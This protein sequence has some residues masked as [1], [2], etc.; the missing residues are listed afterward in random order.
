M[1]KYK[2]GDRVYAENYASPVKILKVVT[3]D[4]D[5]SIYKVEVGFNKSIGSCFE[6]NL[7]GDVTVVE[8][9]SP[10]QNAFDKQTGG[11]HYKNLVIQPMEY[12]LK[13][14]LNYAQSN[15]IKYITR[16]TAKNGLEDLKKAIHCIELLIEYEYGN[17]SDDKRED[18][19]GNFYL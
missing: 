13:N 5:K 16:Y 18:W 14:K 9:N 10:K 8:Q 17:A 7:S 15:A 4:G 11:N 12:A 2:E 6:S 3:D 1:A 19:V